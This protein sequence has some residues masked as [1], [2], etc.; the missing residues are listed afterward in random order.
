MWVTGSGRSFGRPPPLSVRPAR[1]CAGIAESG[2]A[3]NIDGATREQRADR[4]PVE[5]GSTSGAFRYAGR[6]GGWFRRRGMPDRGSSLKR[7]NGMASRKR[8]LS[9]ASAARPTV[10]DSVDSPGSVG[11]AA[12]GPPA[13]IFG[14]AAPY[15]AE[16]RPID[17]LVGPSSIT[18]QGKTE[19]YLR[20]KDVPGSG[21][22]SRRGNFDLS[23][24][25][26]EFGIRIHRSRVRGF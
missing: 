26:S 10:G 7:R 17:E 9:G 12:D 18:R 13:D 8:Q 14:H 6:P 3:P 24:R 22:G 2:Y 15:F 23:G 20:W 16:G 1:S 21:V 4:T 11:R 5:E 19:L 25:L